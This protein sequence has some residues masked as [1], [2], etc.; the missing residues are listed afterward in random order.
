MVIAV[1]LMASLCLAGCGNATPAQ[2]STATAAPSADTQAAPAE[3][4]E[5]SLAHHHAVDSI[6]DHM[7]N[8]FANLVAEK[9]NGAVKITV[10][11][12]AQL[13][14]EQEVAD[15]LLVGTQQFGMVTAA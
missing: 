15:G 5:F 2:Q 13:G 7:C 4:Y 8:D 3:T 14:S 10:Y 12:S 6:T 9:T 11:P 1:A